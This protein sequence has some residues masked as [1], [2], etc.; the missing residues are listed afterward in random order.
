ML[1]VGSLWALLSA[2]PEAPPADAQLLDP[3]TA[4]QLGDEW[5]GLYFKG[6]R[7]GLMHLKKRARPGGGYLFSM[8]TRLRLAA[9]NSDAQLETQVDAA[10]DASLAV[11]RF[12]F[13]VEA[14]PARFGGEGTVDGKVVQLKLRTGGEVVERRLE[15]GSPPVLRSNLGP[16]LSRGGLEPGTRFRYPVFDPLTQREQSVEVEI[17]GPDTVIAFGREVPAT[18]IRQTVSGLVLEGWINHRGEMLRQEL[19]LG[20]VA[21]RESEEEARWG[22]AQARSGRAQADLVAAT[23]VE[24]DGLPARTDR[25]TTLTLRVGGVDLSGFALDDDRQRLVEGRLTITRETPGVGLPLPVTE[26]VP[27]ETLTGDALVQVRH[28]RIIEAARAAIGPASDTLEAARRLLRWVH[29]RVEQQIVVGVPSALETLKTGVGDCNE[30]ATLFAALARSVGVPT[31]IA[32]GL[33][34]RDGRF[35]YHAWNEVRTR[36]AWLSV[37]PTWNQMPVDVGHLR[38]IHGGLGR[39]VE[40][41]RVIGQLELGVVAHQ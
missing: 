20:L 38:I 29:G 5:L 15:L 2:E 19:G 13:S 39:Q 18:H 12:T 33:V 6:E 40:L 36:G 7:A 22:L 25:L 14:G 1:F 24:V 32:V 4:V 3:S 21:R 26:G 31:R 34:Y 37:D 35:G 17:V 16:L 27:P 9:L 8:E 41:L 10:L 30:H 28:P 11:E 23:M